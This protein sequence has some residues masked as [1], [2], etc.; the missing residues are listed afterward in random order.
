MKL[1][2]WSSI[3]IFISAYSPLSVILMIQDF[4]F[5]KTY[6]FAHP[7]FV[8]PV[9]ALSL[10]SC[11]VLWATVRFLKVSSPPVV[12]KKVSNR[13]GELINYSIPY[14][15]S[16]FILDLGSLNQ[17]LS[18][19]FFMF[20]MYW[21]TIKTHNIYINPILACM[22]YNLYDVTYESNGKEY[23]AFFL[24][25][26]ERLRSEETCRCVE[27]SEQLILVTDRNP[28]V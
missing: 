23:E 9:F 25:R 27:V 8:W 5:K 6:R 28:K 10:I 22:G 1:R 16:F 15:I 11:I 21:L 17:I 24:L 26:G 2:I 18:F 12:I 4:D 7:Q 19:A 3:L 13:S 20:I 14:M